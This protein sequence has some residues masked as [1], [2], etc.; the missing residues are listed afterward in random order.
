MMSKSKLPSSSI[1]SAG[2]SE[3]GFLLGIEGG[4]GG[5]ASAVPGRAAARNRLVISY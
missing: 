5:G 4:G 2:S 1:N 3:A